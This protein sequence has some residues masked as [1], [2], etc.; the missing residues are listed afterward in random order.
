MP[1]IWTNF[2]KEFSTKHNLKYACALSKYKEPLK[3]A[4]K[5]FKEKKEWYEPITN[6][7]GVG[8]ANKWTNFVKEYATKNNTTY[9]CALSDIGIKTAYKLFKDGK[10]WYFPKASATIETQTDD[11]IEP[12][13]PKTP[14]NIEPV[15]N[16]IEEKI[17]KLESLG[18]K[19]G[20]VSYNSESSIA[21]IAY[22]NLLKKYGG[23]CVVVN[24]MPS[25]IQG[26]S[27]GIYVNSQPKLSDIRLAVYYSRL[28]EALRD[29]IKRGVK[30]ICIPVSLRF[31]KSK[32]R[33]GHAN[34]LIYRPYKRIVE[35]F[36]PHGQSYG[37]S[38]TDNNA[39]NTQLKKLWEEDLT[40][41]IGPVKFKEP[42]EICPNSKGFQSLENQLQKIKGESGGFCSMWSIFIA[43]MTFINPDKSTKDIID[44]VF[45]ITEKDP[46]YLKSVIR[47]YILEV[48]KELDELL[49]T[50][51]KS[52]F[53]F[54]YKPFET[55]T[56]NKNE[57]EKWIL[58]VIFDS[59][60]YSE[61]PSQ[62]EP[63]P[64]VE[65][66][67]KSDEVKLKETY[68]NKIKSFKKQDFINVYKVYG[69]QLPKIKVVDMP[70]RLINHLYSGVLAKYGA[71]GLNDIDVILEEELHKKKGEFRP[72][73]ARE[74]YFIKKQEERDKAPKE[75][76][77]E[78]PKEEPK[79]VPKEEPKKKAPK[80]EQVDQKE[81]DEKLINY[82]ED[83]NLGILLSQLKP[84]AYLNMEKKINELTDKKQNV[85]V[86]ILSFFIKDILDKLFL[87]Y[88]GNMTS[89]NK[90]LYGLAEI[91]EHIN[92]RADYTMEDYTT[93]YKY[94]SKK[95]QEKLRNSQGYGL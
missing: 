49:K 72:H 9:G 19:N 58:T 28:G 64:N 86:G 51:G 46:A 78:E 92:D 69:I 14:E 84:Q 22:V 73:L 65:L 60:K 74:G 24:I 10:T 53:S 42:Q 17:K 55:I 26:V 50:M 18:A 71:T 88:G 8:G 68:Y 44:E 82:W 89:I 31:G 56:E 20:A 27:K 57:F 47:G 1:S 37:N 3:K 61:A 45:N 59:K 43:E 13:P 80:K 35:R 25:N 66:K 93:I 40:P 41:Y 5:L 95:N 76:P 62:F 29:C 11:F 63:L 16:K 12:V 85:V 77:K 15:V 94:L 67:D 2:I 90:I 75:V 6:E 7:V 87:K 33:S 34:M 83:T 91:T 79:E 81:N 36:E 38:I 52:G 4:Y 32:T 21:T 30:V 70:Y 23:S 54:K 48:E 39:F